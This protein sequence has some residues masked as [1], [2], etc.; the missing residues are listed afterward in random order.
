M[1]LSNFLF[2]QLQVYLQTMLYWTIKYIF[3]LWILCLEVNGA[4]RTSNPKFVFGDKDTDRYNILGFGRTSEAECVAFTRH[5]VLKCWAKADSRQK[6]LDEYKIVKSDHPD[7]KVAEV[8]DIL[9]GVIEDDPGNN[10]GKTT[11]YCL[12]MEKITDATF[13]QL[14]NNAVLFPGNKKNRRDAHIKKDLEKAIRA[15]IPKREALDNWIAVLTAASNA[16]ITDPQGFFDPT[17]RGRPFIFIDVHLGSSPN[18][19]LKGEA[20]KLRNYED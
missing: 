3:L 2:A 15:G 13:F 9:T 18:T 17:S 1:G 19:N 7:V 14:S 12:K 4:R 20:D 11:L 8:T 6:R 10:C 5:S 16:K